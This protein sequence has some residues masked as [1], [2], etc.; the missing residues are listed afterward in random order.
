MADV[1]CQFSDSSELGPSIKTRA[2]KSFF[3]NSSEIKGQK[4]E[5]Q[6]QEHPNI[7]SLLDYN[8]Y[9]CSKINYYFRTY[10]FG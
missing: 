7:I 4:Q 8:H 5:R 3:Y 10:L 1:F 6:K 2:P 9:K